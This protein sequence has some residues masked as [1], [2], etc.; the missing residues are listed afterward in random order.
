MDTTPDPGK[1]WRMNVTAPLSQGNPAKRNARSR[2]TRRPPALM[3]SAHLI[4]KMVQPPEWHGAD[5]RGSSKLHVR[6]V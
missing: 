5:A 4:S 6:A 1:W 3:P 2:A